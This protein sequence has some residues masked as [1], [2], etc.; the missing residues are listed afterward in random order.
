MWAICRHEY[1]RL[2]KSIKSLITIAFIVGVSYW[3]SDLV[4]QAATLIPQQELAKGHALGVFVLIMLLGPLFV[5][6]LSHDVINRE[7]AGRTIRFLVT[8]TSRNKIILGKFLGILC[9]WLSCLVI[10]FGVV[11]ATVHTFDA[12]TFLHCLSL[13]V[14]CISLALFL[15]FAVPRPSYTMFLGIVVAM[16]LP[17]LGLWSTF[18]EQPAAQWIAYLTPF[19]YLEKGGAWVGVIWGYVVLFLGASMYLFQRRDC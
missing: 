12:K 4:N 1:F 11:L 7:L 14:Y 10:T 8:R 15:S 6:S 5:F 16:L 13:L 18:S 2:F 3:V 19:T 9:F 17:G